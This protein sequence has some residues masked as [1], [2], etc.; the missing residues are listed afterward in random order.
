MIFAQALA[1]IIGYDVW[2]YISHILLHTPQLYWI[3]KEHHVSRKLYFY[4]AY[5][6]HWFESPFQ[7]LGFL[8]PF[9]FW[10]YSPEVLL[11]LFIL[12]VKG[13][14]RHDERCTW[15]IGNHHLL[16]HEHFQWNYGEYWID[17]LCGTVYPK[18]EEQQRGL[19]YY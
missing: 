2:F 16:H 17:S 9:L 8:V 4:D 18:V 1:H 19:L 7:S 6:G 13:M 3:H 5:T 12:N 14:L 10:S 11:A 15:I